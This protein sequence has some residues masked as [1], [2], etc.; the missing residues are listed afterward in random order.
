MY[1]YIY[2]NRARNFI[3]SGKGKVLKMSVIKRPIRKD[4]LMVLL[5]ISI[6]AFFLFF[7]V[8]FNTHFYPGTVINEVNVSFLS[9]E[10]ADRALSAQA[11]SFVLVLNERGNV[12]ERIKGSEIGLKF[13]AVYGSSYYKN[14][15]NRTLWI[16]ALLKRCSLHFGNSYTYDETSLRDRYGSLDCTDSSKTVEPKNA[17]LVYSGGTYHVVNEVYGNKVNDEILYAA[18]KSALKNGKTLLDLEQINCY[19]N[20]TIKADSEKLRNTKMV[21]ESYIASK[22]I[23]QFAGGT[24]T[25]GR[26]EISSWIEFDNDLNIVF[27]EKKIAAFLNQLAARY[28]TYSKDRDFVTSSGEK[29]TVGGG[30][31]GWKIDIR[32]EKRNIIEDVMSGIAVVREPEYSQKGAL[33][34]INDIGPT[35]V[36]IDLTRQH[37][38]Y[39]SAGILIA[40]GDVVTGNINKGYKTPEGVYSLKYKIRNAVLKGEDYRTSVSYWMPFNN[41]IGIHDAPWRNAFGRNIYLT[42]G[43]HGCINAPFWLAET[44]FKN[45]SIGTP[46]VC[47]Y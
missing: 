19:L 4:I 46:V 17:G 24:E 30:D 11:S 42:R 40:H 41:D 25:V 12:R 9:T 37:L 32:K 26:N 38:W 3:V 15:Q 34:G 14:I 7:T 2:F 18:I 45:I 44:L 21:A 6:T 27:S 5:V 16:V 20:P 13:D 39:Y 36:E 31:Y 43:S 35:Y 22:V 10:A 28:D 8:F 33:R 1:R 29:I 23:Y 47:Y